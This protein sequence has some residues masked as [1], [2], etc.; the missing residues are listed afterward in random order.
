M[1]KD[2]YVTVTITKKTKTREKNLKT[3]YLLFIL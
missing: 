2:I 3:F 1:L